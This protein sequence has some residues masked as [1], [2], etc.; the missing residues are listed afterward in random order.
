MNRFSHFWPLHKIYCRF[1]TFDFDKFRDETW[2]GRTMGRTVESS[3]MTTGSLSDSILRLGQSVQEATRQHP[4]PQARHGKMEKSF[5]SFKAA[6]P[7]WKCPV[8]GQHLVDR[9]E[10]YRREETAAITREQQLHLEAAARQLETLARLE[11]QKGAG[12]HNSPQPMPGSAFSSSVRPPLNAMV[13]ESYYLPK[14]HATADLGAGTTFPGGSFPT[15]EPIT[16]VSPLSHPAAATATSHSALR[17]PP[18]EAFSRMTTESEEITAFPMQSHQRGQQPH[19][20]QQQQPARQDQDDSVTPFAISTNSPTGFLLALP[21]QQQPSTAEQPRQSAGFLGQAS[22][23]TSS[24]RYPSSSLMQQQQQQLN[25]NAA[26]S[27]GLSSELRRILNMS[28]LDPDVSLLFG[29][30]ADNHHQ[31]S[32]HF[33]PLPHCQEDGDEERQRAE[34][35][36]LLLE[37]Y[38]AHVASQ[39]QGQLH[40]STSAAGDADRNNDGPFMS[41][42]SLV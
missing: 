32:R 29:G 12:H 4:K 40:Q 36:Y 24:H 3:V 5:F 19:Q 35:Q 42:S 15:Q 17:V 27:M 6:H 16:S 34:Q 9:V 1:A 25:S 38:H 31:H 39:Q 18:P 26:L 37:R 22:T 10:H 7:H 14:T 2:E 33:H 28:T 8:S 11:Q 30:V 21:P 13:D 20:E 41:G 23:T